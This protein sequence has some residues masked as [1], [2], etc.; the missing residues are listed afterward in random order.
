MSRQRLEPCIAAT[1]ASGARLFNNLAII[2]GQALARLGGCG[3]VGESKET[4][5]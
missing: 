3:A 2:R 4:G 1:V 5:M